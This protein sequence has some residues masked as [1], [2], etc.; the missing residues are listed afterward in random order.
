MHYELNHNSEI[1]STSLLSGGLEL[2]LGPVNEA[3]DNFGAEQ[4]V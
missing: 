2:F 3:P 4:S 1:L